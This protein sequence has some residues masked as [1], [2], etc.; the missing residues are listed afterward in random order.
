MITKH[1]NIVQYLLNIYEHYPNI[2]N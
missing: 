2:G 1:P